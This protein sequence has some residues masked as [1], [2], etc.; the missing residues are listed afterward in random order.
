MGIGWWIKPQGSTFSGSLPPDRGQLQKFIAPL[1]CLVVNRS[2]ADVSQW[3]QK[4]FGEVTPDYK[5]AKLQDLQD[6]KA[7]K[8]QDYWRRKPAKLQDLSRDPAYGYTGDCFQEKDKA[9]AAARKQSVA[10]RGQDRG[11]FDG[12]IVFLRKNV[13]DSSGLTCLVRFTRWRVGKRLLAN[14]QTVDVR[15]PAVCEFTLDGTL[16]YR[17]FVVHCREARSLTKKDIGKLAD[18]N[19]VLLPK[20]KTPKVC[21]QVCNPDQQ[22]VYLNRNTLFEARQRFW[23]RLILRAQHRTAFGLPFFGVAGAILTDA[24]GA[25]IY[26]TNKVSREFTGRHLRVS[27]LGC[28][29]AKSENQWQKRPEQPINHNLDVAKYA[30]AVLATAAAQHGETR[31]INRLMAI[32]QDEGPQAI[33]RLDVLATRVDRSTD[34]IKKTIDG[35]ATAVPDAAGVLQPI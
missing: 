18:A 17:P 11:R 10:V 16:I 2:P 20:A 30:A 28:A 5:P 8:L 27:P 14:G 33:N 24:F 6:S 22:H 12:K 3:E 35:I 23:L 7:A 26:P 4:V 21:R 13:Q 25:T 15:C 29:S 19:C 9:I 34:W 32:L 1:P 31:A